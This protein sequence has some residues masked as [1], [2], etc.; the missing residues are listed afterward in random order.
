MHDVG[1]IR[2]PDRILK[3]SGPLTKKEWAVMQTHTVVGEKI[4]GDRPFY[5]TPREIARS[6]HERWD[7]TGYPDG[8]HGETIPLP[9]RIVTVADVFDALTHARPYK[10]AW[11]VEKTVT[12]MKRMSGKV[13]DPMILD[14]FF[15]SSTKKQPKMINP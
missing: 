10:P 3:K 5:Q 4:L 15:K 1:K 13:F 9:A 7:G 14:V 6:H 12:E 2:I 11:S 8:L